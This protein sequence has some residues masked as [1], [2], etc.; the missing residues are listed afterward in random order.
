VT[1]VDDYRCADG[2]RRLAATRAD[3]RLNGI[4]WIEVD[5]SRSGL[6]ARRTLLVRCLLPLPP[7]F[8]AAD[9]TIAGGVRVDPAV[10]PVRVLW[11][12]PASGLAAALD[13]GVVTEQDV[14]AFG[15]LPDPD[16]LLVV[17]TSSAGD[18]STYRLVVAEP[19]HRGFDPRLAA[20]DFVFTV[21]CPTDLDCPAP[22]PCPPERVAEP[23]VDYV[24]RDFAG[25]RQLLLDRLSLVLPRWTDR[26][27]ADLGVTL[28]EL[29]AYLGDHLAYAQDS[30][31]AEAY[32][33]T[34][35]RRVS[36]ARHAR[37]LDYRMHQ[38]AAARTWLVVEADAR[39]DGARLLA[40]AEVRVPQG[41]VFHTMHELAVRSARSAIDFYTWGDLRCCLPRGATGATL[42]GTCLDL[43]L[44]AGDVLVLEEV[45][46]RSGHQVDVDRA[47]RWAVRLAA[48]PVDA[49]DPL[50]G[51]PV[52]EVTWREEDELPF[53][54]CLWQFPRGRCEEPDGASV[55]RGNVV[56]IEHGWL[57]DLEPLVPAVVPARG[58]YRPALDQLGLAYAVPYE[59]QQAVRRPANEALDVRPD[60]AVPQV[61]QLTDGQQ[62]WVARP[63]LL[64]SDR[65]EPAYVV[66]MDDDGRAHL[67]F[68]IP[69]GR[70]PAPGDT[71]RA[72]YRIGG[73]PAGNVG[74]DVITLLTH[75]IAGLSVRNPLPARGGAEPE[76]VEQV[77]QW[78]PQAFRVQQRAVTDADYR[79]VAERHPQV[80]RAAATRRWTG[81]WYT[82]FV[83]VDRRGGHAVDR[84]F[85]TEVEASLE[86]F[87][88]AGGDVDVDAP[89]PVPLDI[90]LTVCVEP[91]Q[92]RSAVQRALVDR[93][94]ARDLPG[95]GRGFFHPD[96]L[97]IGEPVYLSAVV[98]AAMGVAGVR[99]VESGEGPD[100]R[101]R[102]RRVGG[103]S[104]GKREAGRIPMQ[105]LEV[106]R[107]DSDPSQPE[108]GRIEFIM[109]GGL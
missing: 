88:M 107:C 13:A 66:E 104:A 31:S 46:D 2:D 17:R 22:A 62:D 105:R 100:T 12:V 60:Q 43:G 77:R 19:D 81:S 3:G 74:A 30:V 20:A 1:T 18:F 89:I 54:L 45:R 65:F 93:F 21:D 6:P 101:N 39:A 97:T 27:V 80:Q 8:G 50:T 76:Q 38:G 90:V 41:P 9:L 40:G 5:G 33:G 49:V 64:G 106:A 85:R 58:R 94:S 34:A 70:H 98:A 69:P 15:A 63:D 82:E 51:T 78:A 32:L 7:G 92:L 11:A 57:V 87:R 61:V 79:A 55:A 44:Q 29:F 56:L 67:R 72:S 26:S 23:A 25:L 91:G 10:N 53:P 59:H 14:R 52:V 42:R 109:A 71:F 37:L 73:G 68:G 75:P 48:E 108:N 102:F 84:P 96:N 99:W 47:H 24:S 35:R 28:V 16:R 86:T 4:D 95:G 103:P 83:T 36:V